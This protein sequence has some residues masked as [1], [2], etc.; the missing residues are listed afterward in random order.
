MNASGAVLL[1]ED[2]ATDVF[3]MERAFKQTEIIQPLFVAKDGIEA[4]DFLTKAHAS[5]DL[6]KYP[7][8]RL[9]LLDL[10]LPLKSGLEVLKWIREQPLIKRV[11]VIIFSSS[12]DRSDVNGAYDLGANG[13]FMKTGSLETMRKLVILWRDC[14]LTNSV[15]PDL[16]T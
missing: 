7:M 10:K 1:V 13:Y 14:W 15:T 8:P 6:D 12:M 5:T 3:L 16:I 9:I 4:V 2:D 11:P